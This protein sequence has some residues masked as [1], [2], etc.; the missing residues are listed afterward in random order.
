[1]KRF[2]TILLKLTLTLSLIGSAIYFGYNRYREYIDNPWTRDGQ[3]RSQVVLVTPQV[4]GRVITIYIHDNQE[5]KK[6]EG[7]YSI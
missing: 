6:K 1:M 4:T 7:G 3:V 5:V 2:F